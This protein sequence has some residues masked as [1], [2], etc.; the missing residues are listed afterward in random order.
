MKYSKE[1]IK[2]STKMI[3][4]YSLLNRK[5]YPYEIMQEISKNSGGDIVFPASTIY[6]ALNTLEALRLVRFEWI[7]DSE[8][9]T[10]KKY[11]SITQLGIEWMES[12]EIEWN[13]YHK[14]VQNL[15]RVYKTGGKHL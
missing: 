5:K 7:K 13:A 14:H 3:I 6:P 15:I 11:Y 9:E 4:L 10:Q 1:I 8:S 12:R 2:G